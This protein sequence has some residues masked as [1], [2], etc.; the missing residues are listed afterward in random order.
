[1]SQSVRFEQTKEES[2]SVEI[3]VNVKNQVSYSVKSYG[4]SLK[5][6]KDRALKTY[7]ELKA[8]L[9]AESEPEREQGSSP[10]P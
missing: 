10:L 2:H 5:Q 3:A 4:S 8:D 7:R 1:M 6:A 9:K